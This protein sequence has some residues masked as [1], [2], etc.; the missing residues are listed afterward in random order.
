MILEYFQ[1]MQIKNRKQFFGKTNV[2]EWNQ[3]TEVLTVFALN[4]FTYLSKVK[5]RKIYLFKQI[6]S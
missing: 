4:F 6:L 3:D 1:I 5:F 2:G